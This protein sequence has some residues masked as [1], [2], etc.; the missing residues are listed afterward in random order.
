M[1]L[2]QPSRTIG[3]PAWEVAHLFPPQGQWTESE[4]LA[5]ATNHLVELADGKLEVLPMPTELHQE[6]VLLLYESLLLFIRP[7]QLGKLLVAPLRVRVGQAKFREPDIVFM[8]AENSDR[9]GNEY[10]NGADLVV[11]V[12][13]DSDPDRDLIDK[14]KEYA[15][16][17][18][19]EYWIVD[20]RDRSILVLSLDE[21]SRQYVEAGR[22][23]TGQSAISVLLDG[24]SVAVKDVMP[25]NTC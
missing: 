20:P 22:Y 17:G 24:F 14:R 10:W 1:S 16:A 11:E 2:Q 21:S 18:I 8:L 3:E 25:R 13:S 19:R 9:R 4:Y 7:R 12:V 23:E 5:L 15:A 6:I